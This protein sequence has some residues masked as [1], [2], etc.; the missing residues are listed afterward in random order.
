MKKEAKNGK[1]SRKIYISAAVAAL[2]ILGAAGYKGLNAYYKLCGRIDHIQESTS[3]IHDSINNIQNSIYYFRDC[4]YPGTDRYSF[5]YSWMDENCLIAHGFGG[6]DGS[7]YT[8]SREALEQSYDKGYRVFECDFQ[9]IDHHIVM[10][11]GNMDEELFQTSTAG[12][13]YDEFMKLKIYGKYT[14]MDLEDVMEFM[15]EHEDAYLMTD[16]KYT[17]DAESAYAISS[18]VLEA[19]KVDPSILDRVIIQI[20]DQQMLDSIMKIYP[21]NSVVYT[22]YTS[23]DS[24]D[25]VLNFCAASG[26]GAVTMPYKRAD[27]DDEFVNQL[28]AI[29]VRSLVHTLNDKAEM[30][31]FFDIGVDMIYTDFAEPAEFAKRVG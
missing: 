24:N 10:M 5:D 14:V 7:Q 4:K 15:S 19:K 13:T 23:L 21:F 31:H 1:A 6:I 3:Y 17:D 26:I 30:E 11:H 2:L 8:N 25:Q 12:M 28:D 9:I 22:L 29:G 16:S 27:T 18:L 20:Y